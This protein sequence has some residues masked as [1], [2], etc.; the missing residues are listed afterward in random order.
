MSPESSRPMSQAA[1]TPTTHV[2]P[3]SVVLLPGLMLLVSAPLISGRLDQDHIRRAEL[4]R[5]LSLYSTQAQRSD[6][7]ATLDQY[8]DGITRELRDILARQAMAADD[9]P[10]PGR[11]RY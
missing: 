5:E 9:R 2:G 1:A 11:G 7:E 8:P 3:G 6:L 4:E 10:L